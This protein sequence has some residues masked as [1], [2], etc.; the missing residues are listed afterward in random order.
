M[1]EPYL[2]VIAAMLPAA[3]NVFDRFH[4]AKKLLEALDEVR[5]QEA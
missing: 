5:R 2:N 3:L 4:I 1:W